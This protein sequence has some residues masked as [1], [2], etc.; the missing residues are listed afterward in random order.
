MHKT[1][2]Q[3]SFRIKALKNLGIIGQVWGPIIAATW[4]A[5]IGRISARG[6]SGQKKVR[7]H[8]NK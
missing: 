1:K 3:Y 2:T 8:L 7:L 6:H 5:K 4:K